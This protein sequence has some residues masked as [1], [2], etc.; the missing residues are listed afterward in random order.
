[1]TRSDQGPYGVTGKMGVKRSLGRHQARQD[2]G[3]DRRQLTMAG[4]AMPEVSCPESLLESEAGPS[5]G[6]A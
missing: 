5:W 3:L 4:A 2:I 6:S 1:M